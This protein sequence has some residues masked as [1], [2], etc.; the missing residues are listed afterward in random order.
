[1]VSEPDHEVVLTSTGLCYE[2]C[3]SKATDLRGG[4]ITHVDSADPFCF[5]LGTERS[6]F[7]PYCRLCARTRVRIIRTR[8]DHCG[9]K[10]GQSDKK[11]F[12]DEHF[13]ARCCKNGCTDPGSIY[14][15]DRRHRKSRSDYLNKKIRRPW[16]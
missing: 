2:Y 7:F 14:W 15:L 8:H 5:L 12:A 3:F 1:M 4:V 10:N 9:P 13:W 6:P 11:G 16:A